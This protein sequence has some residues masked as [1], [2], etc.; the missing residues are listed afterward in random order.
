MPVFVFG[1]FKQVF[2]EL[3]LVSAQLLLFLLLGK[4]EDLLIGQAA[5]MLLSFAKRRDMLARGHLLLHRLLSTPSFFQ[6]LHT[7]ACL[8]S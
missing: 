7:I 3:S 8:F 1:L 4:P 5:F 2:P 6:A